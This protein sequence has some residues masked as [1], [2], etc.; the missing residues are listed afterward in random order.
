MTVVAE[1]EAQASRG[2]N[3]Q[4][5][6]PLSAEE[7]ILR[8]SR[9]ANPPFPVPVSTT[10]AAKFELA[11]LATILRR[12]KAGELVPAAS[13]VA[14]RATSPTAEPRS[15]ARGPILPRRLGWKMSGRGRAAQQHHYPL[16]LRAARLQCARWF[17]LAHKNGTCRKVL[18]VHLPDN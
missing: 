8:S 7:P 10:A 6:A 13:E 16:N 12:V 17:L 15:S 3:P 5:P 4:L 2:V 1:L 9:G 14:P 18:S 11:Q